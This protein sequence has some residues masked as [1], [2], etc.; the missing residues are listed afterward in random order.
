MGV[1]AEAMEE[2]HA[3]THNRKCIPVKR[4]SNYAGNMN[5]KTATA[6]CSAMA[7]LLKQERIRQNL[8]MN[9]VAIRA[10]LAYQ[11]ISYVER[12][13]RIP[14]LDTLLRIG[15]A[16][17]VDTGELITRAEKIGGDKKK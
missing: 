13:A 10:G 8:S 11:M 15:S 5:R 3:P 4:L 1:G 12:E 2:F 7:K 9:A 14:R 6:I 16:L 17:G